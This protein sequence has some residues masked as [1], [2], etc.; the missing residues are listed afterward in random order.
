MNEWIREILLQANFSDLEIKKLERDYN[1]SR[2]W[3]ITLIHTL[4]KLRT[5]GLLFTPE[6]INEMKGQEKQIVTISNSLILENAELQ[7]RILELQNLNPSP[8]SSPHGAN[9]QPQGKIDDKEI[10]G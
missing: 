4:K 8:D 5:A 3:A 7:K 9:K 1:E 6:E 2:S 10:V